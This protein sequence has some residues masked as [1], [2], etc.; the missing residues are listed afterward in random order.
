MKY[1]SLCSFLLLI[2]CIC[3]GCRSINEKKSIVYQAGD[4][5]IEMIKVKG[6]TFVMGVLDKGEFET[7]PN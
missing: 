3:G 5:R 1:S 4:S 2:S 6:G 7:T